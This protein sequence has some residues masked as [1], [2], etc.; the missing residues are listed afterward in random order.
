MKK[1]TTDEFIEK[2]IKIHGDFY[3]YS[4][5]DYINT[6]TKVCIICPKHGRFWQTPN[7][8]L[9]G[10]AEC[11]I[12]QNHFKVTAQEFIKRAKKIH[13]NKYIY[14]NLN[15]INTQEKVN[16]I[17]PQHGVFSQKAESHLLG[18]GCPQCK[19]KAQNKFYK[20]LQKSF[21][22]EELLFEVGKDIIPWIKSQRLDIYFPKYNIAIEYNGVQHY[23]PIEYFGGEL[24]LQQTKQRDILKLQ[25]CQNNKC[26]LFEIRYNYSE[27]DYNNLVDNINN[28]ISNYENQIKRQTIK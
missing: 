2:A 20:K 14:S 7:S 28:I 3:D 17:C 5:V 19:L 18:H 9:S 6:R 25:K 4:E 13:G 22:N 16:I 21:P 1:L 27:Q 23:I 15:Y 8:H 26:Q 24:G 10:K 12:C 11:P